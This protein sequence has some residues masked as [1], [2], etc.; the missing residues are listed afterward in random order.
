MGLGGDLHSWLNSLMGPSSGM[1]SFNPTAGT[2]LNFAPAL[3]PGGTGSGTGAGV[4]P[5]LPNTPTPSV[6]ELTGAPLGPAQPGIPYAYGGQAPSGIPEAAPPPTS[7][8]A[9]VPPG[10]PGGTYP[11]MMARYGAHSPLL[12]QGM[13]AGHAGPPMDAM[14]AIAAALQRA[15]AYRAMLLGS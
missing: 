7:G 9:Y 4:G 11:A 13:A 14:S 10:E 1:S 3:G 15:A 12:A 2:G 5:Y 6:A 8:A